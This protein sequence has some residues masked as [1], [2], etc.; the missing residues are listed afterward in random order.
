MKKV[1]MI[2]GFNGEPNGGWRPWLMGQLE[3][4]N[5]YACALPM[6]APSNPVMEEWIKTISNNIINPNEEIFMIGHSLGV[7]AIL[8]YL[9][10]LDLD[11]KIG[12]AVLVSGPV[13]KIGKLGYESVDSF[14][15]TQFDYERIKKICNSFSI[16]HGDNDP[17][18]PFSDAEELSNFLSCN[19]I[20]VPNGKHLNG[21]A[22]CYQLPEALDSLLKMIK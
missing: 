8:R 4:H 7:P 14:L 16:I 20:S 21:S 10:K 5:I 17:G 2:H 15:E 3:K 19:L 1:F 12:G 22:G 6:P 9:E 11:V 18:V 13:H